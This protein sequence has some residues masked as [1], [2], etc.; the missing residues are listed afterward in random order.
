[1]L[2]VHRSAVLPDNIPANLPVTRDG[3]VMVGAAIGEDDFVSAHILKVVK[4]ATLKL[5]PLSDIDPQAAHVMLVSC[6]MH[7]L[8]YHTQVT[9]PRL[10]VEAFSLWDSS[11]A[12]VRNAILS[13]PSFGRTPAV[14]ADLARLA[15]TKASLPRYLNGLGHISMAL[16]SPIAYY[17]AYS[18]H[19]SLDKGTRRRLLLAELQ[20]CY[21]MLI[22]LDPFLA[23]QPFEEESVILKPE[24]VGLCRPKKKLQRIITRQVQLHRWSILKDSAIP[25]EDKRTIGTLSRVNRAFFVIPTNADTMLA[26][27]RFVAG[28]RFFLGLPQLLKLSPEEVT[29]VD[30]PSASFDFSY[31]ADSCRR[32]PGVPCDRHLKHAHACKTSSVRTIDC[33]HELV[34]NVRVEFI[35]EAGYG[36]LEAEPRTD[37]ENDQR[38]ADVFYTD[39]MTPNKHIHYYTDDTIGHPLCKS[40]FRGER[41]DPSHTLDKLVKDKEGEYSSK[42]ATARLNHQVLAGYRVVV[43][44]VCAMTSLGDSS[45]GLDK[46][47][48]AACGF[49]KL[50]AKLAAR[51]SPRADGLTPQQLAKDF[52]QRFL[53]RLFFALVDGNAGIALA[54]GY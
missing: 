41:K 18:I 24:D 15:D 13:N 45:A 14:G 8:G 6:P 39:K 50:K 51:R 28:L 25:D 20:P 54:V 47:V 53:D 29:V 33:R 42:L 48:S 3:L 4:N 2:L 34:K 23:P 17:A 44:L 40:H 22:Q 26:G 12:K 43:L 1:M 36:D 38:R 7:A 19:A 35:K 21:D 52:K 10:A 49:V 9:P 31:E 46:C 16:I 32:C 27:E 37:R 5:S 30:P 11:V